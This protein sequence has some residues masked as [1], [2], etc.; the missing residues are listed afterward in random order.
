MRLFFYGT[1]LDRDV[2]DA[3][4]GPSHQSHQGSPADLP[5]YVRRRAGHSDYPVLVRR[6]G[7]SVRGEIFENPSPRQILMIAHFEGCKYGPVRK[8][9]IDRVRRKRRPAWVFLPVRSSDATARPWNIKIWAQRAKPVLLRDISRWA[10]EFK[11]GTLQSQDLAWPARR[12]LM[13]I[14]AGLEDED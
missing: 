9:I 8:T 6:R 1:L 2:R 14:L 12:T 10:C 3:V 11:V 4:L 7:R 5:G 13:Q